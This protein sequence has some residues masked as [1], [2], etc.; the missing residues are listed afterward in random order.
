M[1]FKTARLSALLLSS[2]E[3]DSREQWMIFCDSKIS[4]WDMQEQ[5]KSASI[6]LKTLKSL[7]ESDET[8][9][10]TDYA[11]HWVLIMLIL[12]FSQCRNQYSNLS[13]L[14][15]L[16]FFFKNFR[17]RELN[18]LDKLDITVSYKTVHKV[19]KQLEREKSNTLT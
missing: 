13:I 10:E 14:L 3:I 11:A 19:L 6:L 18:L 5:F 2:C 12:N 7:S 4:I 9:C 8:D 1:F 15:D 17:A 16:H